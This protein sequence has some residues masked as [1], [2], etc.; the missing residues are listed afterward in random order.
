VSDGPFEYISCAVHSPDQARLSGVIQL[1]SQLFNV[2][3]DD[4]RTDSCIIIPNT[5]SQLLATDNGAFT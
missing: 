2:D 4:I 5:K 3:I 1:A